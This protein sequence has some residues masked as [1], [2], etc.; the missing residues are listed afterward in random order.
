MKPFVPERM[1]RAEAELRNALFARRQNV[2][3]SFG[4]AEYSLSL[5]PR[6]RDFSPA[7]A[8]SLDWGQGRVRVELDSPEFLDQLSESIMPGDLRELPEIF[9]EAVLEGY[10]EELLNVL[11]GRGL[12][13]TVAE[14]QFNGKV[15]P[16]APDPEAVLPLGFVLERVSDN[17]VIHGRFLGRAAL[18][19]LA[20]GLFSR[21]PLAKSRNLD[22]LPIYAC[23]EMGRMGLPYSELQDLEPGD[24][25]LPDI[26]ARPANGKG[27]AVTLTY[28]GHAGL[29]AT[30]VHDTLTLT[31]FIAETSMQDN[32]DSQDLAQETHLEGAAGELDA[33]ELEIIL[34]FEVGQKRLTLGELKALQPGQVLEA[35][36]PLER[37]VH[38]KAN[39]KTIARGELLDIDGRVGVRVAEF[40]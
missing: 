35:D 30:L 7:V 28:G 16:P 23:I 25:L 39:G 1:T 32:D 37:A 13:V 20:S 15:T 22:E 19:E 34:I 9:Q 4:G 17:A 6:A 18:L 5:T 40:K 29:R 33:D 3:I 26:P 2:S 10:L 31:G 24:I 21:T 38:V 8:F 27:M 11:E 14:V 36:R 12:R